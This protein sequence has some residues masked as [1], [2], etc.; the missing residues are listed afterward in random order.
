VKTNVCIINYVLHHNPEIW[1]QDQ[2]EYDPD[3]WLDS[4][5]QGKSPYL[6]PFSIGHRA[7]IGRNV[8]TMEI[9]KMVTTL[10]RY[11]HFL[12]IFPGKKQ[13]LRSS[14]VGELDGELLVRVRKRDLDSGDK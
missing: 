4:R 3:R 14:G 1:G 12:P 7:C 13:S 5:A 2:N 8:A 10:L 11:Y 9:Y 6:I